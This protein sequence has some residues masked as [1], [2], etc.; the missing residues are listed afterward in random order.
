ME[1]SLVCDNAYQAIESISIDE[2]NLPV[3]N[4]TSSNSLNYLHHE[5]IAKYAPGAEKAD[6]IKYTKAIS[7]CL[8]ET[9]CPLNLRKCG[10]AQRSY[11]VKDTDD[12]D[13]QNIRLKVLTTST[14]GIVPVLT[15]RVLRTALRTTFLP[16]AI[17]YGMFK[18][19]V[20]GLKREGLDNL[21]RA[22]EEWVDLGVALVVEPIAIAKVFH[23]P[24]FSSTIE[25]LENYH[26]KRADSRRMREAEVK[27]KILD[28]EKRQEESLKRWKITN[29]PQV[30]IS[31][32]S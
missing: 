30:E 28:Y 1:T 13:G 17:P 22:G 4:S 32:K 12:C 3:L 24:V 21:K 20:Y 15:Y 18:G 7:Q 8:K 9:K 26:I 2:S 29:A 19:A 10:E 11:A 27:N 5:V 31:G 25:S 23:P 14:I 6:H 16:L